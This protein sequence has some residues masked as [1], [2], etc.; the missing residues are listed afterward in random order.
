VLS[1]GQPPSRYLKPA[2]GPKH[3]LWDSTAVPHQYSEPVMDTTG[4]TTTTKGS[5]R[6][7]ASAR[8]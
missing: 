6:S 2:G 7:A 1:S 3:D 4:M 5:N 8:L